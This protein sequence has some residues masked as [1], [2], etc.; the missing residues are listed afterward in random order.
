MGHKSPVSH[1]TGYELII[2]L[3]LKCHFFFLT[4]PL[5]LLWRKGRAD[6]LEPALTKVSHATYSFIYVPV[7]N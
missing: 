5:L 6:I 7:H 3:I 1:I 4:D 2:L